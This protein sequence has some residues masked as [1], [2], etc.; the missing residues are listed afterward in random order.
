MSAPQPDARAIAIAVGEPLAEAV[1][2][3]V[4]SVTEAPVPGMPVGVAWRVLS[5]AGPHP[6]QR[7]VGAWPDGSVGVLT[8][9]QAAWAELVAAWGARLRDPATARAYVEAYL[10]LTRGAMVAV[11]VVTDVADLPWRPGSASE[12]GAKARL[13]ADAPD[14]APVE[15]QTPDGF[16]VEL[17]LVVD[18]RLQRNRFDVRPDGSF[19]ATSFQ[20]LAE[21]LPFPIVR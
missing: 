10:A 11:R 15:E 3:G 4:A 7:I 16:H 13:L 2:D 8:A 1:L 9:D 19:A 14:M 18:Q 12:E 20:V 5:N 17:V 6:Q 21:G